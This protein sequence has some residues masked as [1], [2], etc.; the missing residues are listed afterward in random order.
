MFHRHMK[1]PNKFAKTLNELNKNADDLR[2]A[3]TGCDTVVTSQTQAGR[4]GS[5]QLCALTQSCPPVAAL[6]PGVVQTPEVL[7]IFEMV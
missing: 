6:T 7:F 3:N 1:R 5:S 2:K 4:C